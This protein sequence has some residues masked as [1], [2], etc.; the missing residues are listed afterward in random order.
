MSRPPFARVSMTNRRCEFMGIM[1][2]A[3]C[4]GVVCVCG[5]LATLAVAIF[6]GGNPPPARAASALASVMTSSASTTV[7]FSTGSVVL[8]VHDQITG[9]LRTAVWPQTQQEQ[10]AFVLPAVHDPSDRC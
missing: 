3:K 7:S 8:S 9:A 10:R 5:F 2:C 6:G 4:G 1:S